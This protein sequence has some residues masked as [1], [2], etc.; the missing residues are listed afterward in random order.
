MTVVEFGDGK[1]VAQKTTDE[2]VEL[3]KYWGHIRHPQYVADAIRAELILR[4]VK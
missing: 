2:L 1:T 3:L 4:G